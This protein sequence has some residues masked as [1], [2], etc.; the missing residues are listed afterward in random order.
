MTHSPQPQT[1]R[2]VIRG[3]LPWGRRGP[4]YRQVPFIGFPLPNESHKVSYSQN[5]RIRMVQAM[6][7]VR[8]P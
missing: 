8:T 1:H 6:R 2:G 5:T 7:K 4:R 3:G